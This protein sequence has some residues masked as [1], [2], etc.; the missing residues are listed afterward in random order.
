VGGT[1][2]PESFWCEF[3]QIALMAASSP[4]FW[5][6]IPFNV[7]L[8][9]IAKWQELLTWWAKDTP[10]SVVQDWSDFLGFVFVYSIANLVDG[11]RCL[12]QSVCS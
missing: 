4:L 5:S 6:L 2:K 7:A 9:M 1:P 11:L 10:F 3:K 8:I 12:F